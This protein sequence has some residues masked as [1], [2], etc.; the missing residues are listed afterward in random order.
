[1]GKQITLETKDETVDLGR[2]NIMA[3]FG[4]MASVACAA[5]VLMTISSSA[6]AT[7]GGNGKSNRDGNGKNSGGDKAKGHSN[8]NAGG[9]NAGSRG[10]G[11]VGNGA[12]QGA[13]NGQGAGVATSDPDPVG[14]GDTI[15]DDHIVLGLF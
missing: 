10:N 15:V 13:T 3:R 14:G 11:G 2:R 1:M 12:G 4:L 6:Q 5:P 8:G 9:A 7:K